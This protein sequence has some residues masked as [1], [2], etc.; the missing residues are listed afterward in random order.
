MAGK[1]AATMAEPEIRRNFSGI[2]QRPTGVK[3]NF[4]GRSGSVKASQGSKIASV[5]SSNMPGR[6]T[7]FENLREVDQDLEES[8]GRFDE[9]QLAMME[10]MNKQSAQINVK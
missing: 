9:Q 3:N 10:D 8:A 7:E 4:S 6:A 1:A 2:E 5:N